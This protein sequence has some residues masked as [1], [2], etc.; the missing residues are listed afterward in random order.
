MMIHWMLGLVLFAYGADFGAW[1]KMLQEYEAMMKSKATSPLSVVDAAYLKKGETQYF[2]SSRVWQQKKPE[3]GDWISATYEDKKIRIQDSTGKV[4]VDDLVAS[5]K[6]QWPGRAEW[7]AGGVVS[8]EEA[9][10][11]IH[12]PEHPALLKFKK[13]DFFPYRPEWA[14]TAALKLEKPYKKFTFT[15]V[16]DR[17]QEFWRVGVLD[18]LVQGKAIQLPAY[19]SEK[20]L[21]HVQ[22]L[23]VP[24]KDLTNGQETYAGGRYA[25]ALFSEAKNLLEAQDSLNVEIDFNHAS[26]PFCAF[27]RFYNC[28]RVP[29]KPM[30]V[31]VRSGERIGSHSLKH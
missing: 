20:E 7:L 4:L 24:F 6:T 8:E 23:F 18:F 14:V 12:D 30:G 29:G 19:V 25:N 3:S 27:S 22:E 26:Q 11:K 31:A 5:K 1:K 17:T 28:V 2:S 10:I 21:T 13:L 16:R 15:T 9:R